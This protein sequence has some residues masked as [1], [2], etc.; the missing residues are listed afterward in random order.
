MENEVRASR[1]GTVGKI[2]VKTGDRVSVGDLL[3][4]V[5]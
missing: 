5:E 2:A 1:S 4:V 3:L